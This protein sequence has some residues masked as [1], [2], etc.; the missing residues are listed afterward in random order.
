MLASFTVSGQHWIF[1]IGGN[2]GTYSMKSMEQLQKNLKYSSEYPVKVVESFPSRPGFE[3]S[4]MRTFKKNSIGAFLSTASTGGR[5][6]YADYSG[7]LN[8]DLIVN[9]TSIAFNYEHTMVQKRWWELFISLR[10][11]I[12]FNEL[13]ITNEVRIGSESAS[14]TERFESKNITLY[15]GVGTRIFY[16]KFF[17]RP[18]IGYEAHIFK[19]NLR[20]KG[21]EDAYLEL[22]ST[23][24]KAE[25]D[26]LRLSL[27]LGYRF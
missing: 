10:N 25:W 7:E 14:E 26:G 9:M 15:P 5:L 18:E 4:F 2:Y 23:Q 11:G 20:F 17:L 3:L 6:S 22:N 16:Q 13:D 24:F 8:Y 19:D 21:R 1:S 27:H 12:S